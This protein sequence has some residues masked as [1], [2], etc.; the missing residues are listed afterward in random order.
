MET[1]QDAPGEAARAGSGGDEPWPDG[2]APALAE[3]AARVRTRRDE[4]VGVVFDGVRRCPGYAELASEDLA[5]VEAGVATSVDLFISVFEAGRR[6]TPANLPAM[7]PLGAQRARL[8]VPLAGVLAGVSVGIGRAWEFFAEEAEA[9]GDRDRV[10]VLDAVD[11]WFAEA[12]S[13][14]SDAM[15]RGYLD[16]RTPREG[17]PS[18][19][20]AALLAHLLAGVV[21]DTHDLECRAGA[22]GWEPS[23]RHGLVLFASPTLNPVSMSALE[24]SRDEWMASMPGALGSAFHVDPVPH[25]VAVACV[26][27]RGWADATSVADQ[28]AVRHG[29]VALVSDDSV[30]AGDV[31]SLYRSMVDIVHLAADVAHTP[32]A[33]TPAALSVFRLLAAIP[34]VERDATLGRLVARLRELQD[35]DDGRELLH[36]VETVA[37]LGGVVNAAAAL[38]VHR[39]TVARRLVRLEEHLGVTFAARA[40]RI[41]VELALHAMRL[42]DQPTRFDRRF[43]AVTPPD[44]PHGAST[45]PDRP[46]IAR[47]GP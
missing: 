44:A 25:A 37:D 38:G 10:A 29:L 18:T 17:V 7:R 12:L 20:R 27:R 11:P 9:L 35:S 6:V 36:T 22:A 41:V 16:E 42:R 23:A 30:G 39:R 13:A 19:G 32:R 3:V 2:V 46:Q 21:D 47:F 34:P 26:P 24:Q 43:W 45:V 28:I 4:L 5:R 40:D 15:A 33:V 8:G 31:P 14:A 1:G